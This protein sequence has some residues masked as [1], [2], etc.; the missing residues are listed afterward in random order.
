MGFGTTMR[1]D[2]WWLELLP[3]IIL[4]GLFGWSC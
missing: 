4:L 2:M 3:V 1:R